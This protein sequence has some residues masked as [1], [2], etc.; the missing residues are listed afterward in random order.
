M[1]ISRDKVGVGVAT[2]AEAAGA[3]LDAAVGMEEAQ[4]KVESLG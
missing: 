3:A 2:M 1:R 4:A